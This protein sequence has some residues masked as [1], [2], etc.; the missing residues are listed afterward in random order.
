MVNFLSGHARANQVRKERSKPTKVEERLI[1]R[2][3][4][5]GDRMAPASREAEEPRKA[6]LAPSHQ[7][8]C[9]RIS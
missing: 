7:A 8:E 9:A 3:T 1:W 6:S 4:T 2:E 5:G